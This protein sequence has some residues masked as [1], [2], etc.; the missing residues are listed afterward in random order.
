MPSWYASSI[1]S[2]R[3]VVSTWFSPLSIS[4]RSGWKFFSVAL[5]REFLNQ[6]LRMRVTI[7]LPSIL[8]AT[9]LKP[10]LGDP[11]LYPSEAVCDSTMALANSPAWMYPKIAVRCH[12]FKSSSKLYPFTGTPRADVAAVKVLWY[13][14]CSYVL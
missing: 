10:E 7:I 9:A 12:S 11:F 6:P 13:L 14:K 5:M 2:S 3:R 4:S 1:M 8:R